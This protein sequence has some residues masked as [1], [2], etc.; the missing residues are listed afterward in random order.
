MAATPTPTHPTSSQDEFK[1]PI[2]RIIPYLAPLKGRFI[3]GILIGVVAAAFYP[4]IIQSF[5]I[6]FSLV[7]KGQANTLGKNYDFF[8]FF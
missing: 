4:V 1:M 8:N 5:E 3:L 6:I 2:K 7:L